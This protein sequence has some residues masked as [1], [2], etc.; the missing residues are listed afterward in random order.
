M[1]FLPVPF[2]DLEE[3]LGNLRTSSRAGFEV[4]KGTET[5]NSSSILGPHLEPD[6]RSLIMRAEEN[7]TSR[8]Q[9]LDC[10]TSLYLRTSFR[11]WSVPYYSPVGFNLYEVP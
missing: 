10:K 8:F 2:Q 1:T 3:S 6:S 5:E 9:D 7:R 4:L 11:M